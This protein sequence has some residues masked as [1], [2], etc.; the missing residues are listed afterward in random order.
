MAVTTEVLQY[1]VR[2]YFSINENLDGFKR[3][4]NRR[5]L[6]LISGD[7]SR[8]YVFAKPPQSS[9]DYVG[10]VKRT[11]EIL[12]N[13]GRKLLKLFMDHEKDFIAFS[14]RAQNA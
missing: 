8:G 1:W 5:G 9:E 11:I 12:S 14:W 10:R 13:S 3:R 2:E 6:E 7:G 4:N